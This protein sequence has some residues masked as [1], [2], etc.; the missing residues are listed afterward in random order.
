M[1]IE[2]QLLCIQKGI[3]EVHGINHR[4]ISQ[5]PLNS[6]YSMQKLNIHELR[7]NRNVQAAEMCGTAKNKLIY[8]SSCLTE[9][10]LTVESIPRCNL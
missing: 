5:F 10:L 1:H 3:K 2:A 9:S 6:R 4:A 8:S 7:G